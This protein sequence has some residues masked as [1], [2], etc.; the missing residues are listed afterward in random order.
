MDLQSV[1]A[2]EDFGILLAP[3]H[4]R[5]HQIIDC[6]HLA[7]I[8]LPRK[9]VIWKPI[10]RPLFFFLSEMLPFPIIIILVFHVCV[11]Y[12]SDRV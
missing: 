2:A 10:M 5:H 11:K 12:K 8:C 9:Q 6:L 1:L 4:P 3:S 7:G